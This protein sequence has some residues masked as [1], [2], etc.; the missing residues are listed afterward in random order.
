MY[1]CGSGGQ[2]KAM[3]P[4]KKKIQ[5]PF[6]FV[7]C[8]FSNPSTTLSILSI[9]FVLPHQTSCI[10]KKIVYIYKYFFFFGGGTRTP[11]YQHTFSCTVSLWNSLPLVY[12]Q[13]VYYLYSCLNNP[14]LFLTACTT[15]AFPG[16]FLYFP[17]FK[18]LAIH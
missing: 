10:Y 8:T 15:V 3:S 5:I 16:F 7:L 13:T 12:K 18:N 14:S 4:M 6:S 2:P 1:S 17:L 11:A 9:Q